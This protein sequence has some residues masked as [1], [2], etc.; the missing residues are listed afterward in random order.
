M[1]SLLA[2]AATTALAGPPAGGPPGNNG[3]VKIHD[4]AGEPSAE[5]KNQPHVCTFHLHFYFAD[6]EQAG[7][8]EIRE[9]APGDKGRLALSGTYDTMG[10]GVDREPDAGVYQLPNGHY[11][12]FWDG[13]LDTAKH[14]KQKVFWVDC[15]SGGPTG[16]GGGGPTGGGG[17]P[18]GG[19]TGGGTTGGGAVAGVGG[20][21]G[22][23]ELPAA[24]VGGVSATPPPTDTAPVNAAQRDAAGAWP[25]LAALTALI[26][27]VLLVAP[28]T[29]F[30]S[31]G[32]SRRGESS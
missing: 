28:A 25:I 3:T 8:W 13:D 7:T 30:G 26:A 21:S 4:G 32:A 20:T 14:D 6:P 31:T 10:D 24:G 23:F 18:I 22:G 29:R 16:G 17:G 2:L 19:T 27:A 11:K 15:E 1:I 12:L 5:V 9:W